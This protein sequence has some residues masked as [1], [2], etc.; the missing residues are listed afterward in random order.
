MSTDEKPFKLIFKQGDLCGI[1]NA[2]NKVRRE[3]SAADRLR[4]KQELR[5]NGLPVK[6]QPREGNV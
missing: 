2:V 6:G 5:R 1:R 3:Q 4:H